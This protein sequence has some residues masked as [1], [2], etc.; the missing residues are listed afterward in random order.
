MIARFD[1][2]QL[3]Y[4]W[5]F[6]AKPGREAEFHGWLAENEDRLKASTPDKYEYLGTFVAVW[7]T[8]STRDSFRQLWRYQGKGPMNLRSEAQAGSGE[9]ANLLKQFLG[10]VDEDRSEDEFF[11]VLRPV[12][13]IVAV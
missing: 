9:F 7:G 10:F 5:G 8:S 3:I 12:T 6:F 11:A 13:E 4:E 1:L 2:M